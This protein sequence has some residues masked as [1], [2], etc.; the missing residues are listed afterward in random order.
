MRIFFPED[1]QK[2]I[3]KE[4]TN[5]LFDCINEKAEW[6]DFFA[7]TKERA[8]ELSEKVSLAHTAGWSFNYIFD[9]VCLGNTEF[10]RLNH[11]KILS[12]LKFAEEIG[13]DYITLS[14]PYLIEM[15]IAKFKGLTPI[16]SMHSDLDCIQRIRFY[17]KMGVHEFVIPPD[18]NRDLIFLK[19]L[20]KLQSSFHLVLNSTCIYAC[21]YKRSHSNS[22]A[23][24]KNNEE[25]NKVE[26]SFRDKCK[27]FKLREEE[28]IKV[29]WIRPEDIS[30]YTEMGFTDFHIIGSNVE[31]AWLNYIVKAYDKKSFNGNLLML[32]NSKIDSDF[33]LYVNNHKFPKDFLEKFL[34]IKCNATNCNEC[35]YCSEIANEVVLQGHN[36]YNIEGNFKNNLKDNLCVLQ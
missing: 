1:N 11:N 35:R 16:V 18:Q 31:F 19:N 3:Y 24:A 33:K 25:K 32:L 20:K 10:A 12:H 26:I 30:F 21:P 27:K 8:E 9:V 34:K 36:F 6:N 17:E 14:I 5:P 29:R 28:F 13:V 22:L 23:H 15:V 2:R 7:L 4:A